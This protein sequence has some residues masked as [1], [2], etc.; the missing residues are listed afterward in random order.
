MKTLTT[1]PVRTFTVKQ[2]SRF[3][4]ILVD[5]DALSVPEMNSILVALRQLATQGNIES[6][7]PPKLLD[8][9][10]VAELLSISV[11]NLKQLE[12]RGVITI[13]QRR[14]GGSIRY[15][16]TDVYAFMDQLSVGEISI[17]QAS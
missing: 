8:R 5:T 15:L 17:D 11:T 2:I 9:D 4:N 12:N 16:N 7:V 13:P 14:L 6:S 10:A 1:A 3:L